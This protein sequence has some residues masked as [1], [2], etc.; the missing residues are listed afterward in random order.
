[1]MR[2]SALRVDAFWLVGGC[3][4]FACVALL[5][6]C[7]GDDRNW[8]ETIPVTGL[9]L[10]DDKPAEG[11][12][13]TFHPDGGWDTAQP[14]ETKAMSDKEGKFA[15]STYEIA[16]GAP[17]GNYTLTIEWPTLN[18][19]SMTFDGD[20]LGGKYSKPAKSEYK[21]EVISGQSVDLG[22]LKLQGKR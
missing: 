9:V 20:A 19:I 7:S 10:V 21:L 3:M 18:K 8:K 12:M 5:P 4:L 14:T 13:L 2:Q 15:A 11:V 17:K 16:D 22:T 1:M 6:G